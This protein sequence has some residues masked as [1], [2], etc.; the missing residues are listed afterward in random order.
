VSLA[1]GA[2][3][4][5][6]GLYFLPRSHVPWRVDAIVCFFV[7]VGLWRSL[8]ERRALETIV[9]RKR[10]WHAC[11]T[12]RQCSLIVDFRCESFCAFDSRFPRR[13]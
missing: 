12:R 1:I 10:D 3:I 8:L 4:F 5:G 2:I 7:A 9:D 13:E 6:A 11:R